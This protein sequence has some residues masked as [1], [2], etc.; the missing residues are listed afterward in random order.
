[1][2]SASVEFQQAIVALLKADAA[3]SAAVG[4]RV[5]DGAPADAT[6]PFITIGESTIIDDGATCINGN[7]ETLTLH[8]WASDQARVWPCKEIVAAVR[9]ALRGAALA[10]TTHAC[11]GIRLEAAQQL[12]DP[13]G[14]TAHGVVPVTAWLEER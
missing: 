5:Y 13:D 12:R 6:Y 4:T 8:I 10:L 9:E 3:V 2:A 7:E 11:A 14:I 1:M